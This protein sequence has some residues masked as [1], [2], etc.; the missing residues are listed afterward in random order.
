[1][2]LEFSTPLGDGMGKLALLTSKASRVAR[3]SGRD[4]EI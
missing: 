4:N 1:M 2:A 3:L